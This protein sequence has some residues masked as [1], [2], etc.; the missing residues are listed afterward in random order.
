MPKGLSD[1]N[2]LILWRKAVLRYHQNRCVICGENGM[3]E[4]HHIVHRMRK[5]LRWDYRNGVPVHHGDCHETANRMGTGVVS[6]EMGSYLLEQ[7]RL[8]FKQ[9]LLDNNLS[10]S[11][12][13]V[14]V[15]A[16]LLA[17]LSS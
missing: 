16:D 17:E 8:T 12:W 14:A 1:S 15:K 9:F 6:Y 4:C 10:E 5:I 2:L 7:A 11:E 3:L 13:R